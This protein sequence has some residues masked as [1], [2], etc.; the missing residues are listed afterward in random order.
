[1]I[2]RPEQSSVSSSPAE[3]KPVVVQLLP[4]VGKLIAIFTRKIKVKVKEIHAFNIYKVQKIFI[5]ASH[6]HFSYVVVSLKHEHFLRKICD[7]D[8]TDN[9]PL[10]ELMLAGS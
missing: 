5:S 7:I 10:P 6:R 3:S 4:S 1:M 2:P 8:Y 9:P